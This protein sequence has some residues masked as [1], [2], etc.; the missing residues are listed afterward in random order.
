VEALSTLLGQR[1]FFLGERPGVV[2]AS[3]YGLLAN[4]LAYPERTP[5]KLA[6]ERHPNLV[7]FCDR[8]NS[9]YWSNDRA[10]DNSESSG[11][12]NGRKIA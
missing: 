1:P 10:S 8:I 3:A 5:L 2:D 6:V 12:Q 11:L 7:E 9:L 4:A